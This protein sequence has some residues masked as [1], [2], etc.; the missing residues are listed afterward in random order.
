M[1]IACIIPTYNGCDDLSRLLDSLE[2]QSSEFDLFVVDSS[3]QDG[4][5]ELARARV[6]NLVVI[7]GS[8]FNHGG[9]RQMMIDRYPGYDVYVFITQDAYLEDIDAIQRLV[10]PFMDEQ[11]GAV[12]GRQ[13]PH[14]D[15][16]PLAQHARLFNYPDVSRVKSLEDARELGIKTP[17]MSNS[18]SAYRGKAIK[19]VG[20]FPVHVILSEDMYVAAKM[21]LAGWK[22]AYACDAQCRHSHDY[23]LIEEFRRY[24]DQGVF[25]ARE[26]WIRQRFGGAG[27]EGLRYVKSELKFLGFSRLYLWPSAFMRNALKLV[28]YKLGQQEQKLSISSKKKLGM[29]KRYW[30]SPYTEKH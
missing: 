6:P 15:A 23:S 5:Q 12:C 28:A 9:T 27:G 22:V 8:E 10:A 2:Y 21:L 19:K 3:S 11:V 30:D 17:F 20:G 24:F 13:V 16:G 7:P 29:Y 1:R 26:P 18:F 4:T 14:L 25:H